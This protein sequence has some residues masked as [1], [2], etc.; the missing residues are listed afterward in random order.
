MPDSTDAYINRIGRTGRVGKTGDA[1]TLVTNEDTAMVRALEHLLN[2]P[3]QR[4]TLRDFDYRV[5]APD[6]EFTRS[7]RE[8][9]RGAQY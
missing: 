5:C 2:A 1:F 4:R 6:K 3:L 8:I 9:R 7:P